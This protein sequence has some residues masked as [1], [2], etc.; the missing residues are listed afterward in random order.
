MNTSSITIHSVILDNHKS[1]DFE[2][3]LNYIK[4]RFQ[5]TNFDGLI[6]NDEQS[7]VDHYR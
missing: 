2:P 7:L 6:D 4:M 5:S 3:G 1:D